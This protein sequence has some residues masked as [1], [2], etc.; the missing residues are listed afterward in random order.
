M[1]LRLR[2]ELC[3]R[4]AAPD[5]S[6]GRGTAA[7]AG[8]AE[9]LR[10]MRIL[11]CS[12]ATAPPQSNDFPRRVVGCRR[13]CR[14]AAGASGVGGAMASPPSAGMTSAGGPRKARRTGRKT[15]PLKRPRTMRAVST[16]KKYLKFTQ[17]ELIDRVKQRKARESQTVSDGQLVSYFPASK[18]GNV[19]EEKRNWRGMNACTPSNSLHSLQ[20]EMSTRRTRDGNGVTFQFSATGNASA[21]VSAAAPSV[22]VLRSSDTHAAAAE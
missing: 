1:V 4:G 9:E 19:T 5:L 12:A 21:A 18:T 11:R 15:R 10:P 3:L 22:D 13:C 8:G 17:E 7:E 16:R 6:A 2:S 14:A 20:L